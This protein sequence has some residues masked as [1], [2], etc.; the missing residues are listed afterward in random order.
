MRPGLS[1]SNVWVVNTL[2][3]SSMVLYATSV[4]L[5]MPAEPHCQAQGSNHTSIRFGSPAQYG[6]Q[7]A[8]STTPLPQRLL[9]KVQ[10]MHCSLGVGLNPRT[11]ETL[12]LQVLK[13]TCSRAVRFVLPLATKT[14][15]PRSGD[16]TGGQSLI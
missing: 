12:A 9:P 1:S 14:T 5:H 11:L 4:Y 16:M 15:L 2:P 10:A 3:S 6:Q 7:P 13:R 8:W